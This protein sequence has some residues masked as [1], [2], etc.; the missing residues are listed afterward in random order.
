V[1]TVI[2]PGHDSFTVRGAEVVALAGHAEAVRTAMAR[3]TL[4]EYAAASAGARPLTGRAIAWATTLP[5]GAKVVVRHSRHGGRLASLTGDLFLR[6]TRAPGELARSLGLSAAGVLTPEVVAYAV[7]PAAGP[8]ARADVVT[9]F[10]EGHDFPDAWRMAA[11]E[12]QRNLLL[13]ATAVLLDSLSR[14][15]AEHPDLNLKNILLTSGREPV[16]QVLDVDRVRFGVPGSRVI[17]ERNLARLNR[18]ARKW[19]TRHGLAI[20]ERHLESLARL[21]RLAAAK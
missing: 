14:A 20:G 8:L 9:R 11:D 16:A 4:H 17:A 3:G 13:A 12:P 5:D 7:Y 21:E 19:R 10:V 6:P 18:S 1:A 2:P 15:G